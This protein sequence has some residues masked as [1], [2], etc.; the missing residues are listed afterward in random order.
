MPPSFYSAFQSKEELLH[1][2]VRRYSTAQGNVIDEALA[3]SDSIEIIRT[4]TTNVEI[5][6][7]LPT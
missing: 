6:S 3:K 7:T 1:R 2:I 4:W 5:A